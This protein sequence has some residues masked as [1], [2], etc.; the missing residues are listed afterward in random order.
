MDEQIKEFVNSLDKAGVENEFFNLEQ[1]IDMKTNGMERI[2]AYIRDI[3]NI[4]N[5]ED[6]GDQV[7]LVQN[8][9]LHKAQEA[10]KYLPAQGEKKKEDS[11]EIIKLLTGRND[12]GV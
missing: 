4:E 11:N 5:E 6:N 12:L 3:E 9:I 7:S 1:T 2:M 10:G 8:A